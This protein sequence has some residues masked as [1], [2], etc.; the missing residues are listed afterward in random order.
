M[1]ANLEVLFS[2]TARVQILGLFLLH[3]ENTF[4][5]RE[6]ERQTGQPIRA[7]QR[8]VERLEE[9]GLLVRIPEGNRVFYRL[10][11]DH[12]LLPELTELF[13]KASGIG[14]AETPGEKQR[15][16]APQPLAVEQPFP[17]LD[18]SPASPLPASLRR[19]QTEREWDGA[20]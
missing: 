11:P 9:A 3:A 2:S 13:R 15:P 7:V 4:Y 14:E 18:G 10:N 5:Q 20:Y 19:R 17:W 12:V 6:I 8:E 16:A 1:S